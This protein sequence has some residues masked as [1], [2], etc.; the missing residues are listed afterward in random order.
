MKKDGLGHPCVWIMAVAVCAIIRAL[1]RKALPW[2]GAAFSGVRPHQVA[3]GVCVQ[4]ID[5]PCDNS[6]KCALIAHRQTRRN[7]CDFQVIYGCGTGMRQ[8]P[9]GTQNGF[10]RA[11]SIKQVAQTVHRYLFKCSYAAAQRDPPDRAQDRPRF[12]SSSSASK[13]IFGL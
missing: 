1:W 5:H 8:A 6:S 9:N 11:L 7:D 13:T 2:F 3:N 12:E 10:R 4:G